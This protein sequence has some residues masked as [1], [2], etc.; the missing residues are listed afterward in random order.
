MH[1][2]DISF[3][4]SVMADSD[5]KSIAPKRQTVQVSGRKVGISLACNNE[6]LLILLASENCFLAIIL[7]Q[8]YHFD[9]KQNI[10][11]R[12][13]SHLQKKAVAVAVCRQG[14]GIIKINGHPL[15]QVEPEIL[16]HKVSLCHYNCSCPCLILC[17][18]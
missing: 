17:L 8:T 13:V 11:K 4:I 2:S 18:L 15:D 10:F 14:S 6:P 5:P 3:Y 1:L 9:N 12:C 16:R 7:C